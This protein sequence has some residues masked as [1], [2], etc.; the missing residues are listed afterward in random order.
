MEFGG[1]RDTIKCFFF[2]LFSFGTIIYERMRR[3][4]RGWFGGA[5]GVATFLITVNYLDFCHRNYFRRSVKRNPIGCQAFVILRPGLSRLLSGF[6]CQLSQGRKGCV[7][8]RVSFV[9]RRVRSARWVKAGCT[10]CDWKRKIDYTEDKSEVDNT[11]TGCCHEHR[12][13]ERSRDNRF[14]CCFEHEISFK[15]CACVPSF[16]NNYIYRMVF[17]LFFTC[18]LLIAPSVSSAVIEISTADRNIDIFSIF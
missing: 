1:V 3:I 7:V 13:G 14:C 4:P 9:A 11:T 17:V 12:S 6:V 10:E 2:F 5:L 18:L 8:P 16:F 15:P